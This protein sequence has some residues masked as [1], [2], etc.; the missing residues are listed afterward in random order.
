M[1]KKHLICWK[2]DGGE[3]TLA[4]S[5]P[6]QHLISGLNRLMAIPNEVVTTAKVAPIKPINQFE[7]F[8]IVTLHIHNYSSHRKCWNNVV[9]LK[10]LFFHVS[11]VRTLFSK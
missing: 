9:S 3:H 6:R 10:S 5:M 2:Q 7:V 1:P 11:M 4:E 8:F